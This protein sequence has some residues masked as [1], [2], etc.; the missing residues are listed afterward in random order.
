MIGLLIIVLSGMLTATFAVPLR[1]SREW[2]WEN[3]WLV[4]ATVAFVLMPFAFAASV[5]Y[6]PFGFYRSLPCRDYMAPVLFGFGWGTAQVT[7]GIAITKVGMAM[8]FA[9]VIGLSALLGS[10]LPLVL[11]HPGE[12][13]GNTG[14]W[15]IASAALLIIGLTLYGRAGIER[16]RASGKHSRRIAWTG[17][18][19]CVF[20]GCFGS[21]I[22]IGFVSGHDIARR[23]IEEGVSP[24]EA[25]LAVWAVVLAAGYFPNL[26]YTAYLLRRND[27]GRL[28]KRSVLRELPLAIAAALL[29]LFGML[30]YG[31]GASIMGKLGDSLGFAICMAVLLLWSS[32]LGIMSGEWKGV[33]QGI[34]VQMRAGLLLII[35]ST[36]ILGMSS[37]VRR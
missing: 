5:L 28:F 17:L 7:F 15:L 30:G 1:F 4:Y 31:M 6:Q 36:S 9:I 10:S 8:A 14:A 35:G 19:L 16:E 33:S 2:A 21:M 27:S 37:L 29:W 22:N 32:A 25:T 23:A 11:F 13:A 26:I 3:T 18:L 12:L 20:T 34:L 24:G